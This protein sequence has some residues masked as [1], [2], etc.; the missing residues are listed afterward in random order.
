MSLETGFS[1]SDFSEK[2]TKKKPYLL[3]QLWPFFK[4]L[5]DSGLPVPMYCRQHNAFSSKRLF[6][7]DKEYESF[8]TVRP[9]DLR[10]FD[11]PFVGS[12]MPSAPTHM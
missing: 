10:G 6:S 3:L 12:P 9:R 5:R 4:D 1:S 2:S 11:V 7:G 8:K